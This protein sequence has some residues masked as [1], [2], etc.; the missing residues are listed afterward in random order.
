MTSINSDNES[1]APMEKEYIEI[2]IKVA[3]CVCGKDGVISEAEENKIYELIQIKDSSVS[4]EKFNKVL[5]DFFE[6]TEQIEDYLLDVNTDDD[7]K[8]I[9]ELCELSASADGLDI[10]ENIALHKVKLIL[11]D[12]L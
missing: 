7:R 1:E 12:D 3:A 9:I 2:V 5:D 6:S 10:K 4:K 8:F 11:G